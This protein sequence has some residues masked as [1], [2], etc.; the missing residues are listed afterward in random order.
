MEQYPTI[1]VSLKIHMRG[2]A[3]REL[4]AAQNAPRVAAAFNQHTIQIWDL[5]A[6]ELLSQFD[7]VFDSG[8]RRV[9]LNPT[10]DL[11]VAAA[12]KKGRSGGIACYDSLTGSRLWHR[13]DIRHNQ[14]LRFSS[15]GESIWCGVEDGRLQRLDARTGE[16]VESRV[17]FR[18]VFD[19]PYGNQVLFEHR[20]RAFLFEGVNSFRIPKLTFGLLHAAFGPGVL[21]MTEAGGPVRCVDCQSGEERWRYEPPADT[22]VLRLTFCPSDGCFYGVEWEYQHGK[23]RLLLRF[24]A[25][26]GQRDMLCQLSSWEEEFCLR[27]DA[28]IASNGELISVSDG[29]IEKRLGFPQMEYPDKV[30]V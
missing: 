21:C 10:G 12:W 23:S 17:G 3:I 6:A 16:T 30:V 28:L 25:D 24:D 29:R 8:G 5:H 1:W 14:H 19:S 7:T 13:T 9:T 11:C 18:D 27:G 2:S 26:S 15:A 4:V 22:H 20:T